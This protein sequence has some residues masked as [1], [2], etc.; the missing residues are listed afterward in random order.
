[1]PWR[2]Y[3]PDGRTLDVERLDDGAWRASCE[4][5]SAV[6]ATPAEA[7]REALGSERTIGSKPGLMAAWIAERAAQYERESRL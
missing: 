4:S 6:A 3:T 5:G 7:I 2:T 1:M